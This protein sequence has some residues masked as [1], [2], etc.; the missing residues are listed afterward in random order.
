[1][2]FTGT[3]IIKLS[4]I[5]NI[6]MQLEDL[7]IRIDEIL[8]KRNFFNTLLLFLRRLKNRSEILLGSRARLQ[9]FVINLRFTRD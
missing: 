6:V 1:M 2:N 5:F 4:N 7:G 3:C 9:R 8:L